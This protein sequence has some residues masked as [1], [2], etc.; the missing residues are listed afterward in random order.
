M[1]RQV[2]RLKANDSKPSV[3]GV[4]PQP[5]SAS[6]QVGQPDSA[7]VQGEQKHSAVS[8]DQAA[9]AGVKRIQP[10]PG[11]IPTQVGQA[12]LSTVQAGQEHSGVQ[13]GQ[14]DS[15]AV[16]GGLD[17]SG[18]QRG[19]PA[20]IEQAGSTHTTDSGGRG[21]GNVGADIRTGLG[22]GL[23][24]S[25][26]GQVVEGLQG[27]VLEQGGDRI[28][29]RLL[30]AGGAGEHVHGGSL[31]PDVDGATGGARTGG[32]GSVDGIKVGQGSDAGLPT[33]ALGSVEQG[34]S[35]AQGS[36]EQ[37]VSIAQGKSVAQGG[38]EQGVSV[39]QEPDLYELD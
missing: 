39:A 36:V 18:I 38:V 25:V 15:T 37:G 20:E 9:S 27:Q 33:P 30:Q 2:E 10:Q 29:V 21:A 7:A 31:V 24:G 4:Q 1:R 13:G 16:Q 23:G 17:H 5:G 14:P 19:Q 6:V 12:D 35:I 22:L 11:S 26:Q 32:K 8:G 28:D 34:I 3:Q